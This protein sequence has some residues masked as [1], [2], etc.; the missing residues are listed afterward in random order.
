MI[1]ELR[2]VQMWI[3]PLSLP[4]PELCSSKKRML[5]SRPV[6]IHFQLLSGDVTG[7]FKSLVLWPS[8]IDGL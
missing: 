1:D 6:H 7:F 4:G 8:Y 5:G 2:G 3:E